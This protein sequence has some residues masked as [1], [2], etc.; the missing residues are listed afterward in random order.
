M[1]SEVSRTEID[2]LRDRIAEY[3]QAFAAIAPRLAAFKQLEDLAKSR[4][5]TPEAV[6]ASAAVRTLK[7]EAEEAAG[8]VEELRAERGSLQTEVSLILIQKK[9]HEDR[10]RALKHD[11]ELVVKERNL[12]RAQ[13]D[14]FAQEQKSF[15]DEL[16]KANEQL[17]KM[18]VEAVALH[19]ELKDRQPG[20]GEPVDSTEEVNPAQEADEDQN[21]SGAED[22]DAPGAEYDGPKRRSD[23]FGF[24]E[25]S[26]DGDEAFDRFFEAD[27]AHD[28]SRDWIL[29]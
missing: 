29:K 1:S 5:A 11:C 16:S 21:A 18:E 9:S 25:A 24:G 28:K 17:S 4:S 10:V 6:A 3:E 12:L 14:K 2:A 22:T 7:R 15:E 13:R 26:E 19:A 23:D 20:E 8:A 27:I